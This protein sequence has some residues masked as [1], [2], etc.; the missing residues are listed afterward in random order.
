[1]RVHAANL[2]I[3]DV[4][5]ASTG[6]PSTP[7]LITPP[8]LNPSL[9]VGYNPTTGT[10]APTNTTGATTVSATSPGNCAAGLIWDPATDSCYSCSSIGQN[11]DP[12]N[13]V[14]VAPPNYTPYIVAGAVV[15][16]LFFVLQMMRG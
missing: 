6:V 12:V 4:L 2:G 3:G 1:M 11:Y 8:D 7:L 16:G 15:I 14:C 13:E 10:V 5:G 9:P